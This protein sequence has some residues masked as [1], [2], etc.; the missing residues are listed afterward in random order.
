MKYLLDTCV[1]SDYFRRVG[2]VH[3]RMHAEPP[4]QLGVSAI[5]EHEVRFGLELKPAPR[6]EQQVNRLFS[7]IDV[8]PFDRDDARAAAGVRASLRK[9]GEPIG[10]FDALLAGVALARRLIFVT[11]NVREFERV[12]GLEVVN[13]R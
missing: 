5:T 10:D 9:G 1:I 13:W 6:L 8:L 7:T 2:G 4:Y 3:E 12:R 11:S